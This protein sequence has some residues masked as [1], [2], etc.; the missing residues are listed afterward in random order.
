MRPR[1]ARQPVARTLRH[2]GVAVRQMRVWRS[3]PDSGTV[4]VVTPVLLGMAVCLLAALVV[5]LLVAVPRL[6]G[7]EK[8][9][10]PDG[11]DSVRG[12]S[13]RARSL[14]AQAVDRAGGV[15]QGVK[16]R[17]GEASAD[18]RDRT[19]QARARRTEDADQPGASEQPGA[20]DQ[21][22]ASEQSSAERPGTAE[23]LGTPDQPAAEQLDAD[24]S[25]AQTRGPSRPPADDGP[26]GSGSRGPVRQNVRG[27]G[28]GPRTATLSTSPPSLT[29][30]TGDAALAERVIDLRDPAPGSGASTPENTAADPAPGT[31]AGPE[32][33]AS[34]PATS[35][36]NAQSTPPRSWNR[37]LRDADLGW[38]EPR[39][40][41][42]HGR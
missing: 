18:L 34:E 38:G 20:S 1:A 35:A 37:R 16:G 41:P 6:R 2:C 12:A 13:R 24:Q 28:L 10:S 9:L 7:G 23:R 22:E 14:A 42:R 27:T 31:P 3:M 8:L 11:G 19:Q 32:P 4:V 36:S 15:A 5:L 29:G 26:A 33:A 21:S 25:R 30:E 40:G 17:A 39:P